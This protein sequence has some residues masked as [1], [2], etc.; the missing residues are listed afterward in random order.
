MVANEGF[1]NAAVLPVWPVNGSWIGKSP[2][3]VKIPRTTFTN[4]TA[5]AFSPDDSELAVADDGVLD[6]SQIA[7]AGARRPA[8]IQLAGNGSIS[9]I[10]FAGTDSKLISVSGSVIAEWNLHQLSRVSTIAA[11]RVAPSCDACA[12]PTVVISPNNKAAAIV[13]GDANGTTIQPLPGTPG[14]RIYA[15]VGT[16]APPV[17]DGAH[18]LIIPGW[19]ATRGMPKI[20]TAWPAGKGRTTELAAAMSSTRKSDVIVV[21]DPG[22]IYLQNAATG[23]VV[24]SIPILKK[25]RVSA[26][27][28]AAV[29]SAPDL[30]AIAT[31]H[32]VRIID[33]YTGS[34]IRLVNAAGSVASVA[35]AGDELVIQQASGNL[36]IW[37]DS[38]SRLR[39]TIPGDQSDLSAPVVNQQG[40][41]MAIPRL[42]GS[43]QLID[44]QA[45]EVITTIPPY[46]QPDAVKEGVAFSPDGKH[47]IVVT[48]GLGTIL[49]VSPLDSADLIDFSISGRDLMKAACAAAGGN[50]SA[51]E[52]H[53]FTGT[54]LPQSLACR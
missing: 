36:E 9:A 2:L 20:F 17:W 51:S 54:Q 35:F 49:P 29:H 4:L 11:T 13:N 24:Q 18:R 39:Q 27:T 12:G 48:E 42:D 16:S 14:K 15:P 1:T 44:L 7:P 28:R 26:E 31:G 53:S 8:S 3:T 52:W 38:G 22:K 19:P 41:L 21:V 33:P 50:I 43:I 10:S 23:L 32:L 25:Y 6:I 30:V 5:S 46:P 45:G 34:T 37:T 47:L 40:T